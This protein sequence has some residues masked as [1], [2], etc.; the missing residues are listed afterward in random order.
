M[1]GKLVSLDFESIIGRINHGLL[2]LTQM[3]HVPASMQLILITAQDPYIL[4]IVSTI[5]KCL[6]KHSY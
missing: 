4:T 1:L 6:F 5:K 3:Y 2:L